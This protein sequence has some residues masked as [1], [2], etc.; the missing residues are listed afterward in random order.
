MKTSFVFLLVVL[1]IAAADGQ[2]LNTAAGYIP[3]Q[4][5]ATNGIDTVDLASGG[6]SFN[7]PLRS[8]KQQEPVSLD[9]SIQYSSTHLAVGLTDPNPNC[10]T[11]SSVWLWNDNNV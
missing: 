2:N 8:F 9:Y 7:I 3:G 11:C 6:V 5:Y 10:Q 1:Y 4:P